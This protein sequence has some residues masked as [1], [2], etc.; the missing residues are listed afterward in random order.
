MLMNKAEQN[1]HVDVDVCFVESGEAVQVSVEKDVPPREP[2]DSYVMVEKEDVLEAIG[3]F[4][5]AYLVQLPE[6]Q[7]LSPA[8]LQQAVRRSFKVESD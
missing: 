5:A 1:T 8:E 3:T 4:V 6:A 7:N 2:L